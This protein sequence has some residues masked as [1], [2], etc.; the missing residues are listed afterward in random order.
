MAARE[1]RDQIRS[2][3]PAA[4]YYGQITVCDCGECT[5]IREGLRQKRWDEISAKFVDFTCS[6]VL[7]TEEA[8]CAFLPAYLLRALD[9]LT[10]SAIVLELTVYSV[11]LSN[12]DDLPRMVL[13]ARLMTPVQIEAIRAFLE[14][15]GENAADADWFRP[16]IR[17]AL[18]KIWV[19]EPTEK[20]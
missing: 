6:P 14:F 7:L 3:F 18:D 2:A 16:F 10:S 13:R 9:D 8:F 11:C 19:T 4:A 17:D 12:D 5:Y 15:V 20:V 1:L